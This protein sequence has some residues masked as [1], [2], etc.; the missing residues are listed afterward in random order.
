M[1]CIYK[2]T[3]IETDLSKNSVGGTEQMRKRLVSVVE[4]DLQKQVAI[5]FSRPRTIYT[6]VPNILYLHDLAEDPENKVLENDGWNKFDAFVFVSHWQRDQYITKFNIPYSKC[7]V[8]QNYIEPIEIT[9]KP[10]VDDKIKIIYHTTP[11]RGLHI[12]YFVIDLLSRKFPQIEW[13]VYSS[14]EVYG[15]KT[16]DQKYQELF[17]SIQKHPNM[18]YHGFQP[19]EKVLKDLQKSHIFFY[20]SIWKETSCIALIE[21]IQAGCICIHSDLGALPETS[22]GNTIMYQYTENTKEHIVRAYYYLSSIVNALNT[23]DYDTMR[24]E[25]NSM[26]MPYHK[27]TVFRNSWNFLIQNLLESKT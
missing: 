11:H 9:E 4:K 2:G 5:H 18:F 21:A 19:R 7:S 10:S 15:W 12:A 23:H 24:D 14:F 1:S 25:I 27:E 8:I 17:E 22:L 26:R 16:R 13:N 20:P 6:D 3:I